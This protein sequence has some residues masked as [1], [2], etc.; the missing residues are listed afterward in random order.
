[1]PVLVFHFRHFHHCL[2]VICT[3]FWVGFYTLLLSYYFLLS[4]F[5]RS[6]SHLTKGFAFVVVVIPIHHNVL[7]FIET[8]L[9]QKPFPPLLYHFPYQQFLS[10]T[11]FSICTIIS[12]RLVF[13]MLF[14]VSLVSFPLMS[15]IISYY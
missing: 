14:S 1:M 11:L 13:L 9:I 7:S 6:Y 12:S 5:L 3:W 10:F 15:N 8:S 4:F 2:A